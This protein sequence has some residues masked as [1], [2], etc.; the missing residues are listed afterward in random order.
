MSSQSF[1]CYYHYCYFQIIKCETSK[2]TIWHTS[3][4]FIFLL[5]TH[6]MFHLASFSHRELYDCI[7]KCFLC[8]CN[9]LNLCFFSFSGLFWF[10][11][12][13]NL[14]N[15]P[16]CV[17]AYH[18][19]CTVISA[20][21]LSSF[22]F[23]ADC[24]CLL[25][26]CTSFLCTGIPSSCLFHKAVYN[27]NMLHLVKQKLWAKTLSQNGCA[28]WTSWNHPWYQPVHLCLRCGS[29]TPGPGSVCEGN[30]TRASFISSSQ[31]LK[32]SGF[33]LPIIMRCFHI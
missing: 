17:H 22:S 13:P 6:L 5:F 3:C 28:I 30:Y 20:E 23:R 10:Y 31:P 21:S 12:S 32:F 29:G 2:V 33:S 14:S 7:F 8:H 11:S 15:H 4:I 9:D 18:N 26:V 24:Y 19:E 27:K 25:H 1:P 16:T